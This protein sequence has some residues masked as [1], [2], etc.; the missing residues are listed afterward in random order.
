MKKWVLVGLQFFAFLPFISAELNWDN[1]V[2]EVRPKEL[3]EK[4]VATFNFT[5]IGK[6]PITIS[7]VQSSCGCT[8]AE[9]KKHRY[10]PGEKGE[11]GVVFT[12]GTRTG[13]QQKQIL[14]ST[15]ST[16]QSL[17]QLSLKVYLPDILKFEPNA[18]EW[19]VGES[20]VTQVIQAEVM[21]DVPVKI[22]AVESTS[23][24]IKASWKE[25]RPGK[26]Y[27]IEAKLYKALEPI[28]AAL[29]IQVLV[30]TNQTP[31]QIIVRTLAK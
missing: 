11:I 15:D 3:V 16:N 1:K 23:H 6:V 28:Y 25:M 8:V 20:N 26:S 12:V 18:I 14:L 30:G 5:N 2:I 22:I 10:E 17:T 9:L 27:Q 19:R 13:F 24:E 21:V 31:K 29:M 7:N 4:I